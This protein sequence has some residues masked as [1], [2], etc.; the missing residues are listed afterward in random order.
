MEAE[1]I[2]NIRLSLGL[3]KQTFAERVGVNLGTIYRWEA[4]KFKP[5]KV[6]AKA[7]RK[8]ADTEG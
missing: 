1:E 5:H 2:K 8:L 7:M 3:S 6:F 4:G